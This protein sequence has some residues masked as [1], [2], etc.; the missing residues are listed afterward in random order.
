MLWAASPKLRALGDVRRVYYGVLG[1]FAIWGCTALHLARP[2]TLIIIA[3]NVGAVIFVV[4]SVHTLIVNRRF[5]PRELQAARWREAC[6][7]ACALFYGSF[8]GMSIWKAVV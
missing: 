8:A 4:E 2:L 3:A 7:I 6:L 1:V 5:L